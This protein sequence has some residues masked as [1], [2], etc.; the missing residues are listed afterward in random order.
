MSVVGGAVE[1]V[2][3]GVT[4][5]AVCRVSVELTMCLCRCVGRARGHISVVIVERL[6]RDTNE[7][8]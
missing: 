1:A 8:I 3:G 2:C 5:P 6:R 7:I 4:R